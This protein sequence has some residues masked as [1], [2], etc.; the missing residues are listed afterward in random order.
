MAKILLVDDDQFILDTMSKVLSD[1][2]SHQ[3]ATCTDA[4]TALRYIT[5]NTVDMV[6]TDIYMEHSGIEL[7][8][9]MRKQAAYAT[10][11]VI[12]ISGGSSLGGNTVL[13]DVAK[14]VG[15]VEVMVKPIKATDLLEAVNKHLS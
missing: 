13:L 3:V 9:E 7:I 14:R 12:A 15:A 5:E 2:G 4:K 1:Q 11:P 10:I 6:V 8:T